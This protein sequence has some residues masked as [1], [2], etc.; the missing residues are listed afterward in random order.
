V[1][2]YACRITAGA[3]K[4]V[5]LQEQTQT[6]ELHHRNINVPVVKVKESQVQ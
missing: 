5:L 3:A 4:Y 6:P 1:T 2:G